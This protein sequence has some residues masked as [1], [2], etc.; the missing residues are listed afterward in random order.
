[1]RRLSGLV[2]FMA[3]IFSCDIFALSVGVG[4]ADL[5]PPIGV[6]SAGYRARQG[7]GMEGVHDPLL[8]IAL[9]IDNGE[10]KI[11]LCSV[12]HLGFSYEMV[13]AIKQKVH[14]RPG[15]SDCELF[16]VSSHTHSGGGA[17]LNIP[18]LGQSL[19][20]TYDAKVTESYVN[21]TVAAI[22]QAS[23]RPIPAKM[24]IGY[25]KVEGLS[26]YRSSWP[27]DVLPLTDV[28]I[29]KITHLD[30]RPLAVLFNYAVHPT[31]LPHE[32][33]LFSADFVGYARDHL[34]SLLGGNVQPLYFNGAQGDLA[35]VV[36]DEKDHFVACDRL[37]RSLAETVKSIWEGTKA[38]EELHIA[39]QKDLYVFKPQETPFG[40]TVPLESYQTEINALIF[41]Q[42][43]A[44]VTIPG[45]LSTIYDRRLKQLGKEE[46]GYAH[47][48]IW[49]L[50]NDAHGYIILP[51]SWKHKT[52]ESRLSF[53]GE[54]YGEEVAG[55][56][57]ALLKALKPR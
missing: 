15:L 44:F 45:E 24:G 52:F 38:Q 2:F 5:T 26:K 48:S 16:I 47:V 6:P 55:R 50:V 12:D 43:H 17:Y 18:G 22:V 28:A 27:L 39:M 36:L 34:K 1:M 21:Q 8:A 53:G 31:V 35:P 23:E 41:N 7:A 4:K 40:I 46:L 37:G 9:Y 3:M 42:S 25:G 13:Q 54:N 11:V 30:D 20:G 19:A 57:S 51:E 29:I 56:A 32:N 33:R 49:G 14:Q 10:K